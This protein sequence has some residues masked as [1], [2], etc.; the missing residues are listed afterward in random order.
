MPHQQASYHPPLGPAF[1]LDTDATDVPLQGMTHEVETDT[2]TLNVAEGSSQATVM[3][4]PMRLSETPN[5]REEQ[6]VFPETD[7]LGGYMDDLDTWQ[8][9][10]TQGNHWSHAGLR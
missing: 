6:N 1:M 10:T 8:P 4:G 9:V 5:R 3:Q 7:Q 2:I